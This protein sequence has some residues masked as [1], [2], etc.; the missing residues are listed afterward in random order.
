MLLYLYKIKK[1]GLSMIG[2]QFKKKDD[3]SDYI[4]RYQRGEMSE[5]ELG[6]VT[7]KLAKRL[8]TRLRDFEKKNLTRANGYGVL[9]H[10]VKQLGGEDATRVSQ[11][12]K[13]TRDSGK[14]LSL[15]VK[16]LS[17]E[18]TTVGSTK[19][20]LNKMKT[21][22]KDLGITIH[23]EDE[24]FAFRDFFK[25]N[26][27]KAMCGLLG[28][29]GAKEATLRKI[30]DERLLDAK[31]IK[32]DFQD[33]LSKTDMPNPYDIVDEENKIKRDKEISSIQKTNEKQ[34]KSEHKR[35]KV[36]KSTRELWDKMFN[37]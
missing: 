15:L 12:A 7:A 16:A 17:V 24:L 13:Y 33:Y 26:E 22:A 31:A 30:Q 8:N 3:L 5:K 10:Y 28:Y 4:V 9:M 20:E 21:T 23:N 35:V 18:D 6:Q 29:S 14:K 11:S 25:T 32:E 37:K 36:D 1:G 19:A 2:K 34:Y 27:W